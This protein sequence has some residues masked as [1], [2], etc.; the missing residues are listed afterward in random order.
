MHAPILINGE[1]ILDSDRLREVRNP[2]N[3]NELVGQFMSG[4]PA[5]ADAAVAA[6][7]SA[8]RHWSS[9]TAAERAELLL[10]AAAEIEENNAERAELLTREHGKPLPEASHDVGGAPKILRYYADLAERFD[11]PHVTEDDLGRIVRRL[12]PMG[13][14]AI[15]VPWNAPVYL[16][17]LMIA[18]ALLAG[19]SVVVKPPSY[20]PLALSDTLAVLASQLPDGVVNV[21]P[22]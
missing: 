5:D 10:S 3:H 17:Y 11:E 14:M 21:V 9:T 20:T 8:H 22:G 18:P 12:H 2:A 19:N 7:N 13:P 4:E 16:A 6:A 1:T 15:I